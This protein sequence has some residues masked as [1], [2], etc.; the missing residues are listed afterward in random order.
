M[1]LSPQPGYLIVNDQI[2][3]KEL[4]RKFAGIEKKLFN[5]IWKELNEFG[6]IK[7]DERGVFFSKRMIEDEQLREIR[8][9][10]GSLGGNPNLNPKVNI[11]VNQKVNQKPTP[12]SSS[13]S[14]YNNT[15]NSI[16][17]PKNFLSEWIEKNL[18][19]VS[20]LKTL[21]DKE[22]EKLL[23]LYSEAQIQ[24]ILLQMENHKQLKKKY[25]STYLTAF[26]WLKNKKD[27][28]NTKNKS[29]IDGRTSFEDAIRGF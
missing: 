13:S 29:G 16:I 18:P 20:T 17:K 9:G 8:R 1:F 22:A 11:K 19:N 3:D 5:K 12:S 23:S 10:F 15:I 7:S 14:S 28:N 6:I 27:D 24:E 2:L 26:N 21:S 4:V 25:N